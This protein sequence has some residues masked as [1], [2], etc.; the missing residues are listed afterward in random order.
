MEE[1]TQP[2]FYVPRPDYVLMGTH[3]KGFSN[4]LSPVKATN[5]LC[6]VDVPHLLPKL[7]G[8]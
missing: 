1:E 2:A 4:D 5:V 3:V 6:N 7:S 8:V